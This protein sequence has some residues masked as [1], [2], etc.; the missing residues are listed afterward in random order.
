MNTATLGTVVRRL[1]SISEQVVEASDRQLLAQFST[2][3]DQTAFATIVRRHGPMVLGVLRRTLQ[4]EQDAE[5]AFQATFLVLARS[6]ASIR[7]VQ[8]LPSW[9]HGVSR[10]IAMK[11]KRS[12]ARRRHHEGRALPTLNTPSN[13]MDWRE[14][15]A[16]LDEEVSRLASIYRTPFILCCLEGLGRDEAAQRLGLKD[17]TL[18]SRLA[19]ARTI[20][21]ERL[22]KRGIALSAVLASIAISGKP[23][24]AETLEQSTVLGLFGKASA[25]VL[26]LARGMTPTLAYARIAIVGV[27]LAAALCAGAG[28]LKAR[29]QAAA[30]IPPVVKPIDVAQPIAAADPDA[31]SERPSEFDVSGTIVGPD[32]KPVAGAVV[33]LWTNDLKKRDDVKV[34]ATTGPDGKY[35]LRVPSA[36]LD[37]YAR[38]VVNAK[39]LVTDWIELNQPPKS[40]LSHTLPKEETPLTGR[41][42]DLEG[43]P[44][45]GA[46]IT[47]TEAERPRSGDLAPYVEA[48][49]KAE[50]YNF[51]E[52]PQT[53]WITPA[54][55]D[56]SSTATTDKD[57][58]FQLPGY[59]RERLLHLTVSAPG[60]ERRMLTVL[61]RP[62]DPELV[63]KSYLRGD[64]FELALAPG[65]V[66]QGTV[67]ERL[68]GM[69]VAGVSVYA[70]QAIATTNEKGVYRMDGLSKQ[71]NLY[72]SA[73]PPKP[74]FRTEHKQIPDT[75][76]LEPITLDFQLDSGIEIT[77]KL[78]DKATGKPVTGVVWYN[79]QSGNTY[80][81]D[82]KI[83]GNGI[84]GRFETKPDGT[85]RVLV[86]PG[87]GYLCVQADENRYARVAPEGWDGNPINAIPHGVLPQQYHVTIAIDPDEKKPDSR[88][89]TVDLEPGTTRNGVVVDQDGKPVEGA[90]ALGLTSIPDP[91]ATTTPRPQR[92]GPPPSGRLKG[93][94]F[95]AVGLNPKDPRLLV[96]I[97]HEKKLGKI[98]E[99]RGDEK[100]DLTVK[101]EPLLSAA[102]R[103]L[104]ADGS[105]VDSY[106]I[107]TLAPRRFAE[108]KRLPFVMLSFGPTSIRYRADEQTWLP[109]AVTTD[110]DGKFRIEGM[111]PGI[112]YE[113]WVTEDP[114][115]PRKF[116]RP[117]LMQKK[118]L[119]AGKNA[120]FGEW[121]L[122]S[123]S[124]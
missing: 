78:R 79:A 48:Y 83:D 104:N 64:N 15:Q 70:G 90:I 81:K 17:G 124:E 34:Q 76:G 14:V 12:A 61:T 26:T 73:S 58:R 74:Y 93:P 25:T 53:I 96:F 45:A 108:Y 29:P 85:F 122:R 99:V 111:L 95:T 18:S 113:F 82:Q 115:E 44:V 65:K 112:D 35:R 41:I 117:V 97:H 4:H 28:A 27:V 19:K 110:K 9:L 52:L 55:L 80:L 38:I 77:G 46:T 23:A 50:K 84:G 69:P 114:V 118:T 43:K 49:M 59:G 42:L 20:L 101:L 32:G 5:D 60:M 63:K 88:S 1:R 102:G 109:K 21:K 33:A 13:D 105:P 30:A 24:V 116:A 6:A 107:T 86:L 22:A 103:V 54:A 40:E 94:T 16:I 71:S 66:M 123:Q 11:T 56:A 87:P 37:R 75:P 39:G 106:S 2:D 62:V 120:D 47:V 31:K 100:G 72:V 98:I 51:P 119:D 57:G 67:T 68:T 7:D 8:A 89:I 121:K 92:F 10:R 91:G 3:Q 36:A